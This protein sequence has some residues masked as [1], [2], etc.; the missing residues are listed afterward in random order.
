MLSAVLLVYLAREAGL[1]AASIGLVMAVAGVG[2]VLGALI[3]PAAIHSLGLGRGAA[4]GLIGAGVGLLIIAAAPPQMAGWSTAIGMFVYGTAA[5]LWQVSSVTLRQQIAPSAML[6]RVTATMRVILTVPVPVA[7]IAGGSLGQ[8][9]G[10]RTTLLLAAT[11]GMMAALSI[12]VTKVPRYQD[13]PPQAE[14]E[15]KP[16][17]A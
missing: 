3:A 11:G 14:G 10:L 2:F 17:A 7:A 9:L 1:G 13:L 15:D 8:L 16:K 5:V 6:G 12:V 4:L